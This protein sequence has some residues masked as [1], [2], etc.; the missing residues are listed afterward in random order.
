MMEIKPFQITVGEVASGF[1][2]SAENGVVAYDGKLDIRPAYQREFVYKDAKRDA[3]IETIRNGFP[4]NVMY[5]FETSEGNYEMLDGQQRTISFCSY[6]NGDFSIGYQY[7]HNLTKGEQDEIKKYPLMVF[8]CKGG[9]E[10]EKLDWFR[11][12]NIAGEKL[13]EQEMRN[14]IYTGEWLTEA[15][16]YFSKTGCPAYQIAEKYL[17]GTPIRQDFLETALKWI[18]D[19][20]GITIPDYM[21]KHQHDKNANDL[22]IYFQSVI[23]WVKVLFPKYRKEMKGLDWGVLY[24]KYSNTSYDAKELEKKFLELLEDDEVDTVKGIYLYL[25]TGEE[26][27]LN[28]RAFDAKAKRIKYEEQKGICPDCKKHYEIDEME[29]DH[30]VPWHDGGKTTLENCACRCRH[31]NRVKS[32]K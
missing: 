4:L 2:D 27:Y 9:T 28:L 12:I 20:D 5:W 25:F 10:K 1:V 16:R 13:T 8:I 26:K 30:I 3:V 31:C 14:A 7:F 22:W 24:N 15:K 17:N 21:S 19:R 23:S 32:G 11:I 29:A 6:I 18:A